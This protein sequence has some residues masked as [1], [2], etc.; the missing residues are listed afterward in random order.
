MSGKL[1]QKVKTSKTLKALSHF[2][3]PVKA[4]LFDYLKNRPLQNAC[5][6]ETSRFT[7]NLVIFLEHR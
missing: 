4:L 5:K 1:V 6:A 7:D 3:C 2:Y